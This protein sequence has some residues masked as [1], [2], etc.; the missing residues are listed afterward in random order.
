VNPNCK[1]K[2]L[3]NYNRI[4]LVFG[5]L[6]LVLFGG[7]ALSIVW[8]RMEISSVA[9]NCGKLEGEMEIVSREVYELRGQKS[10]SLRPSNLAVMV[11]D[12]LIMPSAG[13]TYYVSESDL[14]RR[15]GSETEFGY[16][17]QGEFAGTR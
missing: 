8:L 13:K 12:R 3:I 17:Q 10:K 16:R 5:S 15:V 11:K 4:I 9:K 1:M 2:S 6:I 7:G 14:F